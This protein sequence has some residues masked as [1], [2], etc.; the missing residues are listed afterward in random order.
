MPLG[1]SWRTR[2]PQHPADARRSSA[3]VSKPD[4]LLRRGTPLLSAMYGRRPAVHV[5]TALAVQ[6][7]NLTFPRI[8]RVQPCI[9]PLNAAVLAAG[10]DVIR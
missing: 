3:A 1:R 2:S 9:R 4:Y 8:V 6:E 10:P 7:E 5:W